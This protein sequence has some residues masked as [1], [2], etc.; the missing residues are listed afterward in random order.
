MI[1]FREEITKVYVVDPWRLVALLGLFDCYTAQGKTDKEAFDL[2]A[3]HYLRTEGIDIPE[4][5][6]LLDNA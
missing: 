5:T 1:N 3:A 4:F 2:V 6:R